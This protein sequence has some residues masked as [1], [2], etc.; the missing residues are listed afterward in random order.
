M[1]K[2]EYKAPEMEVV[3]LNYQ[4]SLLSMSDGEGSSAG[5]YGGDGSDVPN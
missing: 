3:K 1:K 2:I 4:A 5:D